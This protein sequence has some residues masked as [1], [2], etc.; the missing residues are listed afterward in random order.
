MNRVRTFRKTFCRKVK[1]TFTT[2]NALYLVAFFVLLTFVTLFLYL[3]FWGIITSFKDNYSDFVRNVLGF[4]KQW[5]FSN[6]ADAFG[7]IKVR[8]ASGNG[9]RYVYFFELLGN[10][11]LFS[12]GGALVLVCSSCF[13]AY[14]V[15]KFN[16]CKF[17]KILYAFNIVTMILP[18]VGSGPSM[19][20]LMRALH[21]YDT[22]I[23]FWV[24]KAHFMGL[25]F[26]LFHAAFSKL[27]KEYSEAAELDGA[28]QFGVFFRIAL[29]L[30]SGI[31]LTIFLI[32]F[33][34]IW[35][36]YQTP[37]VY[38]PT[39]PPLSTGV[40]EFN[41]SSSNA[42]VGTP[43]KIAGCMILFLPIFIIFLLFHGRLM[44]NLSM[45]GIKE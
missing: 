14:C 39:H 17:S 26:L 44:N 5:K 22:I 43:H 45:G 16:R 28:S 4:P 11:L 24:T 2:T 10:S 34:A 18:I 25:N 30:V 3:L 42:T 38:M 32:E 31:F 19:L 8:V 6:Y 1:R 27:S 21:L 40:F 9:V 23:G 13:T 7:A 33:V 41:R 37:L 29:P 15:A 36:D 20:Q 12:V 35:N